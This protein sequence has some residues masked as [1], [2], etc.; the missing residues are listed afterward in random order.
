MQESGAFTGSSRGGAMA[1]RL[2]RNSRDAVVGGVAAGFADY[3]DIDPVIPR[4]AF[5]FLTVM[6]GTGLVAY[7]LCWV[8]MPVRDALPVSET[9]GGTPPPASSAAGDAATVADRIA[10]EADAAGERISEVIESARGGPTRGRVIGGIILIGL[11]CLFL[12][13][14]LLPIGWWIANLWPVALI[15]LGLA[16]VFG[17]RRGEG[18]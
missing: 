17:A 10:R 9:A 7:V 3:F 6:G 4:L 8:I 12:V 5:V 13:D 14:R 1:K 11:G 18:R 16:V 15:L 2:T